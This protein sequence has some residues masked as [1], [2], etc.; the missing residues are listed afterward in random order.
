MH[1]AT[2][3]AT[4]V[5]LVASPL[6]AHDFW[7]QPAAFWVRPG[8]AL[9]V[10][11]LVG[12]G[13]A[14]ERS[15]IAPPRITQFRA[16]G[17][18]GAVDRADDLVQRG[19]SDAVLAFAS[20]GT[21]V[22]SMATSNASSNLP[23][24][25][26]NEYASAEGLTN[27]LAFR[28][29]QGQTN[30]PGR[31]FYS[32]RAK[33]LIQVGAP[34][35]AAQPHV[36]TPVGLSLEIVPLRNPYAMGNASHLPVRVMF[37]GKPLAGAFVKLTNLDDDAKPSETHRSDATGVASFRARRS[38]QWQLNVVWSEPIAGN[39]SADFLTVFTSLTFG[40][41]KRSAR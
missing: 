41:P 14:R 29:A 5:C 16:T 10:T 15:T 12:H 19:A 28:R 33:A 39:R 17:P 1:T 38:G 8:A 25:R 26:F 31:E 2:R 6:V 37:K 9:P 27:V 22:V 34:A 20:P 35:V 18:R 40:F 23:A 32:R 30:S 24:A 13:P 36:V 3:L 11:F 7:L 21:Y 4:L